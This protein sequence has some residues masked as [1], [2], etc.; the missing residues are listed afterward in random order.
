MTFEDEE[1]QNRFLIENTEHR[2]HSSLCEYVR[3][4]EDYTNRRSEAI[5]RLQRVGKC[6]VAKKEVHHIQRSIVV[7]QSWCRCKVAIITAPLSLRYKSATYIQRVCL[8]SFNKKQMLCSYGFYYK[9]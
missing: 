8:P 2:L 9:V 3:D 4:C 6:Y 1:S 5:L 7:L